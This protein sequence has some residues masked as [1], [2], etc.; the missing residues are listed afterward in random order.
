MKHDLSSYVP[1]IMS[2]TSLI[3]PRSR[4]HTEDLT[5]VP[6]H[7]PTFTE[8]SV[9]PVPVDDI[10]SSR[11]AACSCS[12]CR[13]G[14]RL[15]AEVLEERLLV[16]VLPFHTCIQKRRYGRLQMYSR[17]GTL[18][19]CSLSSYQFFSAFS[20]GLPALGVC[21]LVRGTWYL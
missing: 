16:V 14:W 8:T 4:A 15:P 7:V 19:T 11:P 9:Q 6:A 5:V 3:G 10:T 17:P 18:S 1:I 13:R 2:N 12:C 20:P 21:A